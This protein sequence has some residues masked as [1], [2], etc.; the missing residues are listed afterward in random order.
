M[1][2]ITIHEF[3]LWYTIF[4]FF[5]FLFFQRNLATTRNQALLHLL[6]SGPFGWLTFIIFTARQLPKKILQNLFVIL[7]FAAFIKFVLFLVE[8][9]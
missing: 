6:V 1:L 4:G 2:N 7:A 9:V 8:G 5:Y 3:F